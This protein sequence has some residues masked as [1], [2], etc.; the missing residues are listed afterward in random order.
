MSINFENTPF[1]KKTLASTKVGKGPGL[2]DVNM[3]DVLKA[4]KPGTAM[5]KFFRNLGFFVTLKG[6]F[7]ENAALNALKHADADQIERIML[8]SQKA[9]HF[10]DKVGKSTENEELKGRIQS[11][12]SLVEVTRF[13]ILKEA[14]QRAFINR[15]EEFNE[16]RTLK[17]EVLP[18]EEQSL[19]ER[20]VPFNEEQRALE[21]EVLPNEEQRLVSVEVSHSEEDQMF[22]KS[23]E[24]LFKSEKKLG[25]TW[26]KLKFEEQLENYDVA[27]E[28]GLKDEVRKII[29]SFE[30]NLARHGEKEYESFFTKLANYQS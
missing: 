23:F 2:R 10:I 25:S 18:D 13:Q 24:S 17:R 27:V 4:L 16:N 1:Y 26:E 30:E 5:G 12:N 3:G 6:W 28:F 8:Q 21:R 20:E 14:A 22:L 29:K 9:M 11:I 7:D 19:L 15:E